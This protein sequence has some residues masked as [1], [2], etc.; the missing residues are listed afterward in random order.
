MEGQLMPKEREFLHEAVL[1]YKPTLVFEVGTWKGGGSTWQIVKALEKNE[2]GK[3]IT[4]ENDAEF[5]MQAIRLYNGHG[6]IEIRYASS[7][8]VVNEMIED[9]E[10]P[11]FL[12]MD[13]P[14]DRE[15]AYDDFIQLDPLMRRGAI[16]SMHDWDAPSIKAD[17]IRPY[18]ENLKTWK[19]IN[20]L[21][22][23]ES[24]GICLYE[25]I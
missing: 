22:H 20:K 11:D 12:F 1:Q 21:T 15:T 2:M 9:N 13:G 19:L 14:E 25:K 5:Y 3:V 8:N 16:F 4:C 7:K 17:S 6:R 24:V 18:I 10:I 23:P